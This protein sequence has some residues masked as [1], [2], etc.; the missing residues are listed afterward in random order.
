MSESNKENNEETLADEAIVEE[1][2]VEDASAEEASGEAEVVEGEVEA[3]EEEVVEEEPLSAEEILQAEVANFKDKW[4][5]AVAETEN[6]RKRSRR[7]L[8]DSRRFAQADILRSFL[9]VQDNMERALQSMD[10][11]EN[12]QDIKS[13]RDGVEMIVNSFHGVLKDKGVTVIEARGSEFDP[14]LHEA[15]G[16]MPSEDMAPDQ[17]LEV[18]QQGYKFGDM[19]LRAARVIVS[20]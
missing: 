4:L 2:P 14:S 6:V 13:L 12:E 3:M 16:Q 20:G 11:E 18:V 5:R 1:V 9:V 10:T 17:V 15:I 7:E 8:T 19:V